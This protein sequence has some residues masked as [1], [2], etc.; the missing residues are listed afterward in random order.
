MSKEHDLKTPVNEHASSLKRCLVQ[1]YSKDITFFP[2]KKYLV[3]HPIDINPF[4][5][6][7]TTLHDCGLRDTNLTKAFGRMLRRKL[8][9]RQRGD[10]T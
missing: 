8:Q 9:E 6:S 10:I 4:T 5:C 1:E 3:A 7:I 2:S